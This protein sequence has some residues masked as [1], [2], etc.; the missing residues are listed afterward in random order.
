MA[1]IQ[2][3]FQNISSMLPPT[4][5]YYDPLYLRILSSYQP[6]LFNRPP[7]FRDRSACT[8]LYKHFNEQIESVKQALDHGI[9]NEVLVIEKYIFILN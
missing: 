2:D 1:Q 5:N 4:S 6:L 9:R 7:G 3:L 8:Q